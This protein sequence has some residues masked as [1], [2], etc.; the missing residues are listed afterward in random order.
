MKTFLE[1]EVALGGGAEEAGADLG[2]LELAGGLVDLGDE[3]QVLDLGV[4]VLLLFGLDGGGG[5]GAVSLVRKPFSKRSLRASGTSSPRASCRRRLAVWSRTYWRWTW[6]AFTEAQAL[7]RKSS[8][9]E[10]QRVVFAWAG[11]GAGGVVVGVGV[12]GG[13]A[14]LKI[15]E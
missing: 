10:P 13:A 8:G 4:A 5:V 3:D 7:A 15:F 2:E 9:T 12:R 1:V 14:S 6:I 11:E